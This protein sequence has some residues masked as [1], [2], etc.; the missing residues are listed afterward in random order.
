MGYERHAFESALMADREDRLRIRR[1]KRSK[2]IDNREL[3]RLV[4]KLRA[5]RTPKTLASSR[6]WRRLRIRAV[7]ASR[8]FKAAS[9]RARMEPLVA[10]VQT[11][12]DWAP[13]LGG[14]LVII[15]MLTLQ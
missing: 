3:R 6:R 10:P 15:S 4:R 7:I 12:K 5:R 11:G 13:G 8:G 9:D 1:C 14:R 2:L